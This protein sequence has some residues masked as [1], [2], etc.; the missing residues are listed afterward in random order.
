MRTITVRRVLSSILLPLYLSSC[1]YWQVPPVSP[2]QAITE[3]QPSKIRVTLTDSSTV[4]M[5]QPRIVGDTLRGLVK[6]KPSSDVVKDGRMPLLERVVL[7][8]DIATLRVRNTSVGKSVLL[9]LG[10]VAGVFAGLVAAL[11]IVCSD[12]A[13]A[14]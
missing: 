14:S 11:I 6:G 10:I 4:E 13:C 9:G 2:E 5:E 8:A 12:Q 7:L 1:T 3:D